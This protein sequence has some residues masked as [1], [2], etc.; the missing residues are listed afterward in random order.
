[1]FTRLTMTG[2]GGAVV[3]GYRTA[4]QL[5]TWT[6]TKNDKGQWSLRGECLARD[7]Y[8][9]RQHPLTFAATRPQGYFTWPILSL[10][11]E[12][13]QVVA[14]LGPPVYQ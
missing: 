9:L 13:N 11:V 8:Q 2:H 14:K 1:M 10:R 6:A 5:K 4:A 12:Q 3:W 7:D